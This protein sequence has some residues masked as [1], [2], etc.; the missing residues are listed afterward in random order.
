MNHALEV[1]SWIA[2]YTRKIPSTQ[3]SITDRSDHSRPDVYMFGKWMHFRELCLL[4]RKT[5]TRKERIQLHAAWRPQLG[6]EAQ[7]LWNVYWP[8]WWWA[9]P[10]E[11]ASVSLTASFFPS[12]V[13]QDWEAILHCRFWWPTPPP[14]RGLNSSCRGNSSWCSPCRSLWGVQNLLQNREAGGVRAGGA[15]PP[16]MRS[17]THSHSQEKGQ[18]VFFVWGQ[19][20]ASPFKRCIHA[21]EHLCLNYT[22]TEADDRSLVM[23]D[24][25]P[26]S[27]LS[28]ACLETGHVRARTHKPLGRVTVREALT[29]LLSLS[30]T[31]SS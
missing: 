26:L 3:G 27:Q 16:W 30:F 13:Q 15:H 31:C 9:A 5:R 28:Q 6:R 8:S 4:V 11:D 24:L 14:L 23:M 7:G 25:C 10:H 18:Q 20:L 12:G 17:Y 29:V 1:L 19:T 21:D 2:W 22:R